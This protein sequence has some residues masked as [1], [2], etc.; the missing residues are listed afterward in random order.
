MT[1]CYFFLHCIWKTSKGVISRLRHNFAWQCPQ[2]F[3]SSQ[4]IAHFSR[5]TITNHTN[6]SGSIRT[7]VIATAANDLPLAHVGS[8]SV[9]AVK[10]WAT[11]L[12]QSGALIDVCYSG[13]EKDMC[14]MNKA[15]RRRTIKKKA[16]I[17][18]IRD[19]WAKS[20]QMYITVSLP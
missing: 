14:K 2:V 3:I 5:E 7:G 8:L 15:R 4:H 20:K 1:K 19:Q 10:C 16:E 12:G 13:R 11:R 18:G 9:D 17:H 6:T